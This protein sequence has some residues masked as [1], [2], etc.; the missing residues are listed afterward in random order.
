M[1]YNR[2]FFPSIFEIPTAEPR[3][4]QLF[5]GL[6]SHCLQAE[7]SCCTSSSS[8]VAPQCAESRAATRGAG[9][10]VGDGWAH[11]S[12]LLTGGGVN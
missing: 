3:W 10:S 6:S 9:V 2:A 8:Q 4:T 5:P 12:V 11:D 7:G 1:Y